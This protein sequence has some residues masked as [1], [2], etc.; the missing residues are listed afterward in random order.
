METLGWPKTL[1]AM[2]VERAT[3]DVEEE[4]EIAQIRCWKGHV[5]CQTVAAVGKARRLMSP[6]SKKQ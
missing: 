4:K 2:G 5:N 3:L 1:P 6:R